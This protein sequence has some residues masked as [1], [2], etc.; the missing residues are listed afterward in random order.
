[1]P[2]GRNLA[3]NLVVRSKQA[4]KQ[5]NQFETKTQRLSRAL[6]TG[7]AVGAA[8]AGAAITRFAGQSITAASDANEAMNKVNEVFG[9]AAGSVKKFADSS[10]TD[11]ALSE[12]AAL[13]A[14]GSFGNLFTSF[15][16][17]QR[18]AANMST[19]LVQ[20]AA[21]LASF[22]NVSVDEA[23][24]ALSSGISGEMEAL[25]RFG[26]TLSDVR[27]RAEATAMGLE[28]T[29]G[30]LDPL[31][32]SLAS[33]SLIMKDSTNAQGDLAR[34]SDGLANTQKI[35]GAAV[36]NAKEKIGVGFVNALE[37]ASESAGGPN[38]LALR[39]ENL[40]ESAGL[41]LEGLAPLVPALDN[42]TEAIERTND[43]LREQ[44][45][46][47]EDAGGGAQGYF[48]VL[49]DGVFGRGKVLARF[50]AAVVDA[51]KA[52]AQATRDA[53]AAA[54][55]MERIQNHQTKA[56]D[57]LTGSIEA[58]RLE[59]ER[60]INANYTY[61]D[62]F[63]YRKTRTLEANRDYRD[64]AVRQ[65][66]LNNEVSR[67]SDEQRTYGRSTGS[68]T[69]EVE[70]QSG[71]VD[72]LQD[73]LEG[74]VGR[75]GNAPAAVDAAI[76]AFDSFSE[77]V[78]SSLGSG[79]SLASAFTGE[80]ARAEIEESG[81]VSAETW[82]SA[83]QAQ[84]GS[85]EAAGEALSELEGALRQPNGQLI[86]GAEALFQQ[87]LTV[88]P[89]LI[90]QVVTELVDSGLAPNL[91]G[92]L[93]HIFQGPVGDAWALTFRGEGLNA[94]TNMLEGL[95]TEANNLKPD[96]KEVGKSIGK[97]IRAGIQAEIDGVL[98]QLADLEG[99][100]SGARAR[101]LQAVQGGRD[102]TAR[103]RAA[104]GRDTVAEAR[105][106]AETIR[107]AERATGAAP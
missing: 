21:D 46:L 93:N 87:I 50:P 65:Y 49:A 100:V 53:T 55:A 10:V 75:V 52:Q 38:G 9:D 73:S 34:T 101:G 91:A 30:A 74:L 98:A 76:S 19:E 106:I 70:K 104:R 95:E 60:L 92:S 72:K 20:L 32:K 2:Q 43:Q 94:A 16:A 37:R 90:P 39:I 47:Y 35:L 29:T 44:T 5:L 36:D 41:T 61:A 82:I 48:R 58:Q 13:E 69:R 71:A 107:A 54:E 22:E 77:N 1:M 102:F 26:I 86:A 51:F 99:R 27:L 6:K 57:H 8:A 33:Y 84:L 4:T 23:L 66:R 67:G 7:L 45:Q 80:T 85:A 62:S 96:L 63:D 15:G 68:A 83:F 18:E 3:I 24:R 42:S 79:I 40:G 25:K 78:N 28:V 31:T 81:R 64:A 97:E 59:L 89:H 56:A 11:L 103:N 12:G 14:A 17:G 88:P 105:A